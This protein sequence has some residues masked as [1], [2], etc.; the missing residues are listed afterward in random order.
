MIKSCKFILL[1][2]ILATGIIHSPVLGERI[3]TQNGLFYYQPAASVYG[4]EAAWVNS[5]IL[6]WYHAASYQIIADYSN[7]SY[8]KSW[9]T[10]V[11]RHNFATATR[12]IDNPGGK[13]YNEYVMSSGM[14]I[15]NQLAAGLS[16]RYFKDGPVNFHKRHS[17][18]LS[19]T[20][21]HGGPL[22]IAALFT[23]L[24]QA[25]ITVKDTATD[26]SFRVQTETEMRYSIAYRPVNN[27]YTFAVDA[28]FSTGQRFK[29][30]EFIYHLSINPLKGIFIDGFLNSKK[31]FQVGIRLNFLKYFTGSKSNYIKHDDIG[32]TT[33]YIGA[34]SIRQQ[35]IIAEKKRGLT[36]QISGRPGENP[37]Q[38]VIGKSR[39]PFALYILN[40]YRAADDPSIKELV[41]SLNGLSMGFGQ[42]QELRQALA[43]FKDKGKQVV[44]HLTHPNNIGY[45]TAS[46]AHKI[47]IPPVSQLQLVGLRAEL[48][49][50]AGTLDKLGVKVDMLRIGK[51][52]SGAE[53]FTQ[54]TPSKETKESTNRILDD[55]YQQFISAIA[56]GRNI[57][58]DSVKDLIDNGP[59][60]SADAL[61]YNLVDGLSYQDNLFEDILNPI[62]RISFNHYLK[63]TLLND[64]W[65]RKP[66]IALVVAEGEITGNNTSSNPLNSSDNITPANM[67]GTFNY[68]KN[69]SDIKGIVYRINSPGGMAMAGE[70]IHHN[71]Q[72]ASQQ[73][74]LTISMSNVA[75]SGGYYISTPGQ[76]LFANP[77]TITGSIGIYGGKADLSR[78]YE[79]IDL[80]KELYTRGKYAG[81]LSTT[82]PFTEFERDKYFSHLMAFYKH[83]L[84][85]VVENRGLN[86]DSIDALS[87]GRVW[88]GQEALANGLIDELGGVKQ[89]LDYTAAVLGIKDYRV[90]IYPKKR[91]FILLPKK[92]IIGSIFS[93]FSG[94]DNPLEKTVSS[95][96]KIDDGEIYTRMPYDIDI[97]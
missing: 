38:P 14:A 30:A 33:S 39:T 78:L 9:G 63:D 23:N 20:I 7:S 26:K 75:A 25:K 6:G 34:T 67:A 17:W 81:M 48:T 37:P 62:P 41:L 22:T 69:I 12:H 3:P 70:Q 97:E 60:T 65:P 94:D 56:N 24:N 86:T 35:S 80:G 45:Y 21:R 13:A 79:N 91:P 4:A 71:V 68:V 32:Y 27:K 82:R 77:G 29:D 73:K 15:G 57:S 36:M 46:V 61:D 19:F 72:K 18:D 51:Y 44:C 96:T 50:F 52:K 11:A 88:T 93:I 47:Y 83:F 42:A 54:T 28:L 10:V 92:G 1:L 16:Y 87:Q 31:D 84:T 89:A 49:F 76:R 59:F 95:L 66:V 8:A 85:L 43:Y 40:I 58:A 90:E 64:G 5:S 2:L 74:P 55:I 53:P